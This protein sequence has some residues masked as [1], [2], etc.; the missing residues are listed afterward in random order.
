MET[1]KSSSTQWLILGAVFILLLF[2]YAYVSKYTSIVFSY[3]FEFLAT[4]ILGAGG[5]IFLI[6]GIVK[7]I[8]ERL[9][10]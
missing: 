9:R 5:V 7:Y 6:V 4:A 10:K 1:K 2:V 3:G 8:A